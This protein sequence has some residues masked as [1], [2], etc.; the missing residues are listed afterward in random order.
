MQLPA[1]QASLE[2]QPHRVGRRGRKPLL[3]QNTTNGDGSRLTSEPN[4]PYARA[5]QPELPAPVKQV[6]EYAHV[7]L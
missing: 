1:T 4:R 3:S 6:A 5:S 2:P 7:R